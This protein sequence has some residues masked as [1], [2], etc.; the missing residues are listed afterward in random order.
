MKN[1]E[2]LKIANQFIAALMTK[3]PDA[4]ALL[5]S[6]ASIMEIIQEMQ[7]VDY[8]VQ[9]VQMLYSLN[10]IA[11]KLHLLAVH[12]ELMINQHFVLTLAFNKDKILS[13]NQYSSGPHTEINDIGMLKTG[14][15][16]LTA[17]KNRD[18]PLM[19]SLLT[20]DAT[21]TLPGTSIL[22]GEAIGADAVLNRAKQ[23]RNFGVAVQLNHVLTGKKGVTLSLH[24]TSMRGSLILDEQVSIVCEVINGKISKITTHLNDV[25]GINAFFV[26]GII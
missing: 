21:W 10:G 13:M 20:N 24:N 19:H 17:L 22:S 11:A 8:R 16:F 3:D 4:L 18:W 25:E 26:D 9:S 14:N 12:G 7:T 6:D 2:R 5:V 1:F 15:D 23:L